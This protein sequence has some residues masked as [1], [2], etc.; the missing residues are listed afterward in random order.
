[1]KEA[2]A[3]VAH[4]SDAGGA[5]QQG[6]HPLCVCRPDVS[7]EPGLRWSGAAKYAHLPLVSSSTRLPHIL[8][9]L[10]PQLWC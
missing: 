3:A 10:Q 7:D 1:M 4:K 5:L 9:D 2:A 6:D 8:D